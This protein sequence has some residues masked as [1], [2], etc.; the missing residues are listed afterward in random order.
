MNLLG[1]EDTFDNIDIL[2]LV[3]EIEFLSTVEQDLLA[4]ATFV[5]SVIVWFVSY[6]A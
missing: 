6:D 3:S 1:M 2:D 5:R 4:L